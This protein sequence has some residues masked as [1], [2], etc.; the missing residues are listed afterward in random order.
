[1]L[2]DHKLHLYNRIYI[3]KLLQTK[4]IDYIMYPDWL[5]ALCSF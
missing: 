2:I 3:E 4:T 5:G 1:M